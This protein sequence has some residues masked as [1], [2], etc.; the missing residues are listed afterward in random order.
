MTAPVQPRPGGRGWPGAATVHGV[1]KTLPWTRGVLLAMLMV[2]GSCGRGPEPAAPP[3]D[4]GALVMATVAGLRPD[5]PY[6]DPTRA[7]RTQARR[8]VERLLTTASGGGGPSLADLAFR[9]V[10]GVDP[11]TGRPF[12]LFVDDSTDR[13][14]GAVLVDRSTPVRLVVQVPHPG[15]D[16][17]TEL[18]GVDLHRRVPGSVL[19]IAGAH[20]AA[21]DG[22]ADVAHN[23]RSF[24]HA[25][26]AE[27]AAHGVPAIQLHGFADRNLP[28]AEA[29]V[30]SAAASVT[31]LARAVAD[32]LAGSGVVTCRAWARRCGRLEGTTNEQGRAAADHGAPFVH[33][34]LGWSI[35]SAPARRD[36]VIQAVAAVFS[37]R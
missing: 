33:L 6:R 11:K 7:E 23:D 13:G 3:V 36:R 35:R 22:D 25:V 28:D 2:L 17:D 1:P 29:V 21:A 16:I 32:E 24:F 9:E 14:W 30:S 10:D 20:R 19:L 31:D 18:M 5:G 34:E 15:F 4:P 27:F 37:T 26:S 8:A 12:R